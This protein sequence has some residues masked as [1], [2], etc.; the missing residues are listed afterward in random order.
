MSGEKSLVGQSL[1]TPVTLV[2]CFSF[3]LPQRSRQ[4]LSAGLSLKQVG[5]HQ[6]GRWA[7]LSRNMNLA[8]GH[9]QSTFYV[10][11]VSYFRVV[12]TYE[13]SSL[14]YR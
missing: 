8:C 12:H 9:F 2:S 10:L 11:P 6:D 7:D 4:P 3:I 13:R 1:P 14:I 5:V